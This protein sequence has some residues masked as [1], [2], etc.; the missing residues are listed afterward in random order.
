MIVASKEFVVKKM[1]ELMLT[2]KKKFSQNFLTDYEAVKASIDSL[3]DSLQTIEIGPGLGA[4]TQ[5]M[6]NRNIKVDAYDI[7]KDMF[8]HLSTFFENSNNVKVY[9][10][11]FMKVDLSKYQEEVNII[12]NVPYNITTPLI[13]KIVTSGIKVKHFEF[14]VQKEVYDRINAKVGSKDYSPLNI[15]IQYVGTLKV[16]RKVPKSSFI[17]VPNVDS[18]ILMIDFNKKINEDKEFN[19]FFYKLIKQSF[20]QRRKTLQNNLNSFLGGKDKAKEMIEKA[21]LNVSIRPDQMTKE[22]FYNLAEVIYVNR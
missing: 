4:L 2:P 20:T 14:M 16:V 10:E 22:D 5:E 11:D 7:D 21:N 6:D 12:S 1:T 3:G 18:I 13:E 15:F 8:N 19:K 17:P 9:N